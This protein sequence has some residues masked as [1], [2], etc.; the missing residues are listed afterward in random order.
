[1]IWRD[2][3]LRTCRRSGH[4]SSQPDAIEKYYTVNDVKFDPTYSKRMVSSG[5]DCTVRIW[6]H[7]D[8]Y[9]GFDSYDITSSEDVPDSL[10][11]AVELVHTNHYSK[12]PLDIAYQWPKHDDACQ[13]VLAVACKDGN[14]YTYSGDGDPTSK[15]RFAIGPPKAGHSVGAIAWGRDQTSSYLFAS[16]EPTDT[17]DLTGAHRALDIHEEKIAYNFS[18]EEA[19]D[20]MAVDELGQRLALFT[21]GLLELNTL[22]IYDISRK[23]GRQ[24]IFS[25]G[26]TE[27]AKEG[28]DEDDGEVNCASFSPDGIYLAI[29]RNDNVVHVYDSRN[30]ERGFL[31][32]FKHDYPNRAVAGFKGFGVV[33]AQWVTSFDGR[34]LGLVSGGNDGCVRLW[35]VGQ[36]MEN[37]ANGRVIA[38]TDFDIAH[39]SIGNTSRGEAPLVIGDSGGG[40]SIF[41]RLG[42]NQRHAYR[43]GVSV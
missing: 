15:V 28:E 24:P 36:A 42:S 23:D 38:K 1:M 27:F 25:C 20:A 4:N 12:P 32:A 40:L 11:A 34:R 39:F 22:R 33:E 43:S 31:Y 7:V 17:G 21:R 8:S 9:D 6:E 35:D 10:P 37:S 41:D 18:S 26:L 14:L 3:E 30:L 13:P 16:S 2:N 19:G 29:A 5:N